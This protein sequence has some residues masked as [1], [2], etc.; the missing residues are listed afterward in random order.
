M[1]AGL[2]YRDDAEAVRKIIE[3]LSKDELIRMFRTHLRSQAEKF[4]VEKFQAQ[5]REL[6]Q[7]FMNCDETI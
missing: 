7:Q 1:G 2:I 6:I 3:V 5:I 4:S